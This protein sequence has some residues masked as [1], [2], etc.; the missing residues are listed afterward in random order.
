VRL[1][2]FRVPHPCVLCKGAISVTAP[3]DLTLSLVAR[4]DVSQRELQ[5]SALG[6]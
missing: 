4:Y 2:N 6:L 3:F 1:R 5:L